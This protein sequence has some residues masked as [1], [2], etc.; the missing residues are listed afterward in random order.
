MKDFE[1]SISTRAIFI[2]I[3][4]IENEATKSLVINQTKQNKQLIQRIAAKDKSAGL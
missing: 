2:L 1:A 4:L 3:E